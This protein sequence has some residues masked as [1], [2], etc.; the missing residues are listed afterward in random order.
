M[1]D[2]LRSDVVRAQIRQEIKRDKKFAARVL[3]VKPRQI[4]FAAPTEDGQGLAVYYDP[5]IPGA[6]SNTMWLLRVGYDGAVYGDPVEF[7][8]GPGGLEHM[9]QGRWREV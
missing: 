2:R 5:K 9:A 8:P 6:R 1:F 3:G 7:P 4:I